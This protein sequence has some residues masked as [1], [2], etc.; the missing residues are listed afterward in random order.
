MRR[1]QAPYLRT[2]GE[3]RTVGTPALVGNDHAE[4]TDRMMRRTSATAG[5]CEARPFIF[6]VGSVTV[7]L[8]KTMMLS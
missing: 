8:S 3:V 2:W 6:E 7:A 4:M 5:Q 1:R